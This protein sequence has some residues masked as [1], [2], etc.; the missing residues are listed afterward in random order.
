MA[1]QTAS[2]RRSKP[3]EQEAPGTE[4][5]DSTGV[6]LRVAVASGPA[7]YREVLCQ[8][9]DAESSVEVS[10]RASPEDDIGQLLV[11][12][13]SQVLLF[14]YEALGPNGEGLIA[15]LR[16]RSPGTRPVVAERPTREG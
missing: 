9:L 12:T 7:L 3:G 4:S 15:R 16:R 10:C 6:P 5:K 11:Q 14:D 8:A 1:K 13:R 2:K